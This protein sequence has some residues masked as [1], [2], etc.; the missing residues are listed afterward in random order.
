MYAY[1]TYRCINIRKDYRL[2][3]MYVASYTCHKYDYSY[4]TYKCT[5]IIIIGTYLIYASNYILKYKKGLH[6]Q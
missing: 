6:H 4:V 2:V 5:D 1:N 3:I